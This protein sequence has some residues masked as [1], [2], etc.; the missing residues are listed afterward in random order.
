[1][2]YG[3]P[4]PVVD[5]AM[6]VAE[7]TFLNFGTGTTDVFLRPYVPRQSLPGQMAFLGGHAP[8]TALVLLPMHPISGSYDTAVFQF[9][10]SAVT[11]DCESFG[12]VKALYR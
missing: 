10:G 8:G 12:A 3:S 7:L 9:N 4:L 2:S 1:V 6:A 5:E 11:V